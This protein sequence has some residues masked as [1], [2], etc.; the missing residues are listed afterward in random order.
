LATGLELGMLFTPYTTYFGIHLTTKFVVITFVAHAIFG[1]VLGLFVRSLDRL[2][3][4]GSREL[5]S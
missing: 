4:I 3:P 5:A 2:W 1:V